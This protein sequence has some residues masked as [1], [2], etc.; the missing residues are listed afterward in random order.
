[1]ITLLNSKANL[2][3]LE[4]QRTTN[5]VLVYCW[6]MLHVLLLHDVPRSKL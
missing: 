3:H 5:K 1:M 6:C 4:R 2:N